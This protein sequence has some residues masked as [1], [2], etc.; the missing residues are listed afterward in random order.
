MF[1]GKTA[2]FVETSIKPTE[3]CDYRI[4][5]L[6]TKANQK[7]PTNLKGKISTSYFLNPIL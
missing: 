6:K 1:G 5:V 3:I 2:Q 4:K 7:A